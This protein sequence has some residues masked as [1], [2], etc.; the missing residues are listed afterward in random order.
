MSFNLK[1]EN[2]IIRSQ[3]FSLN[4]CINAQATNNHE[5]SENRVKTDDKIGQSRSS[6]NANEQF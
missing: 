3:F 6:A 5:C 4:N 2:I 1:I